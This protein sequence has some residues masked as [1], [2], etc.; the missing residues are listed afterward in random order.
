MYRLICAYSDRKMLEA[1]DFSVCTVTGNRRDIEYLCQHVMLK[2]Q[3]T[4]P[5]WVQHQC[6][7]AGCSEGMVTIDGNEKL[8]RA[9]CAAP[10]EKVKCPVN[11][12]NLVQCCCRSPIS[13]GKHQVASK[14][15]AFHQY[16]VS[17]ASHCLSLEE[18]LNLTVRIPL[19]PQGITLN[20]QNPMQ[21][22]D[23][24]MLTPKSFS[25]GVA[26]LV[27]SR[28]FLTELQV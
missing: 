27:R 28:S 10:K 23:Y 11:H 7:I 22:E 21:L 6:N 8:T 25:L 4:T 19:H 1:Q 12:I 3:S 16:L 5:Q 20:T 24:Q 2:A 13:G 15:C 9:M 26:S 17:S 14:Y 18:P